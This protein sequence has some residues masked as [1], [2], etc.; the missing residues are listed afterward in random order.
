M[1][2]QKEGADTNPSAVYFVPKGVDPGSVDAVQ[3][4]DYFDRLRDVIDHVGRLDATPME[5]AVAEDFYR[6]KQT[7]DSEPPE[8]SQRS[9]RR[10]AKVMSTPIDL[11]WKD[12]GTNFPKSSSRVGPKYQVPFI[13]DSGSFCL[14]DS[15]EDPDLK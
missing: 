13:P 9:T 6:N 2:P 1:L 14:E 12:G 11:S 5:R 8:T 3:G 15:K 10:S 7:A 4:E